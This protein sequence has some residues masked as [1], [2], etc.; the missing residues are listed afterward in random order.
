MPQPPS[1]AGQVGANP[2]VGVAGLA[3]RFGGWM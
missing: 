2:S 3:L 1:V